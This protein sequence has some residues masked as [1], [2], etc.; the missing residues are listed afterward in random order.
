MRLAL[1]L[2]NHDPGPSRNPSPSNDSPWRI[3]PETTPI[4]QD[5]NWMSLGERTWSLLSFGRSPWH[6]YILEVPH[7]SGRL[8][9]FPSSWMW[10]KA[11]TCSLPSGR[12]RQGGVKELCQH[13]WEWPSSLLPPLTLL[14][15]PLASS[16]L[17]PLWPGLFLRES[18][19]WQMAGIQAQSVLANQHV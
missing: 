9:D 19:N 6:S 4:W 5:Q 10:P 14:H 11:R 12:R 13:Q 15:L 7:L 17:L 2:S 1:I 18:P 8:W 3:V 16:N